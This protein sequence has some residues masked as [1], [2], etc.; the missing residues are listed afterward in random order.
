M[1]RTGPTNLELKNLILELKKKSSDSKIL[2]WKRIA[3][4]LEKPS[5]QRRK[6]NLYRINRYTRDDEIALVPGKVLSL[7]NIEKKI[8]IAALNFSDH[9][10][11]KI[12]AAGAKAITIKELL[13]QNPEGKKVRIIG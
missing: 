11:I 9:A 5:R 3:R 8:T 7:G 10:I 2:L 1:K 6:A 4:D 12:N 13:K